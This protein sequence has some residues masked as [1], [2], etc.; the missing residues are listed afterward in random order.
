MLDRLFDFLTGCW[1]LVRPFVVINAYERGVRLRWGRYKDVLEPGPHFIWPLMDYVMLA[2]T[3]ANTLHLHDQSLVTRDGKNVTLC[4]VVTFQVSDPKVFLLEVEGQYEALSDATYGAVADHVCSTDYDTL[5]N[6][7]SWAK[8]TSAARRA[9]KQ[10][11]VHIVRLQLSDFT[12][13]KTLRLLGSH[14]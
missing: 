6:S 2:T 9:A 3:V 4:G 13:S 1:D 8:L 14:Q 7:D 12:V 5:R 11:G 10:Y